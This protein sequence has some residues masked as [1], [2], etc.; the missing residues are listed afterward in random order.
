MIYN[1]INFAF[2]IIFNIAI[3]DSQLNEGEYDCANK[4]PEG[5]TFKIDL[6]IIQWITQKQNGNDI[7]TNLSVLMAAG[8]VWLTGSGW[9]DIPV[10]SG[11]VVLLLRSAYR[12]IRAALSALSAVLGGSR[13]SPAVAGVVPRSAHDSVPCS[14]FQGVFGA[15]PRYT[16]HRSACPQS[17]TMSYCS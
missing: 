5:R 6:C 14:R 12:V 4:H 11:L 7:A 15:R 17:S 8:A 16:R 13:R 10:A 1:R 2:H 9:P 3:E